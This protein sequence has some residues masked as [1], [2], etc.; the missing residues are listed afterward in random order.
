[1]F[2]EK[3]VVSLW[4]VAERDSGGFMKADR[5]PLARP[6]CFLMCHMYCFAIAVFLIVSKL[7]FLG[8]S[9]LPCHPE[10]L[11]SYVLKSAV[12]VKIIIIPLPNLS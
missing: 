6:R 8:L 12:H 2:R 4:F 5:V 9:S 3:T 10:A 1:M 7:S 11:W